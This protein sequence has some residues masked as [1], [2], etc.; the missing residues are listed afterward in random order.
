M[1][2]FFSQTATFCLLT[3]AW[4]GG[5]GY[6]LPRLCRIP[7][8]IQLRGREEQEQHACTLIT[9]YRSPWSA[10]IGSLPFVLTMV[11]LINDWN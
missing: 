7:L 1:R 10:Y 5:N 11:M 2:V 9:R 8:L 3:V 4:E 6:E